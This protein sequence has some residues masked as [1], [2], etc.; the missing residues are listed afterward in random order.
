MHD[1]CTAV[2]IRK[3]PAHTVH[4]SSLARDLTL[5]K[6]VKQRESA[7]LTSTTGSA[8]SQ[9]FKQRQ[10]AL[11]YFYPCCQSWD[12]SCLLF[13]LPSSACH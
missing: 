1:A 11:I 3:R 12:E 7:F 5:A 2:E 4:T 9:P 8:G 13:L 6:P 10:Q